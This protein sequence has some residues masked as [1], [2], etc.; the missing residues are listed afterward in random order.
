MEKVSK[1]KIVGPPEAHVIFR[2]SAKTNSAPLHERP[3]PFSEKNST[4][5]PL[6]SQAIVYTISLENI[7][8]CSAAEWLN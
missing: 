1:K 7:F 8:L 4:F 3:L 6:T 2:L 5:K